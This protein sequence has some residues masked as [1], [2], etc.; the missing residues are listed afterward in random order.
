MVS[1]T[2]GGDRVAPIPVSKPALG[3]EE[4]AQVVEVLRS[5]WVGQGP[6]V[7]EFERQ[8][9]QVLG[10][11]HAVAVSSG[12]A[13]L[14]V[15]LLTLGIGP[16]DAVLVPDF[17]FP[18]SANAVRHCGAEPILLDIDL[19]TLNLSLDGLARFLEQ[20]TKT[21]SG[22]LIDRPSGRIIKAIMAV[23]L[24]GLPLAM[25]L[26]MQLAGRYGLA[27]V[28]DA[29]CALGA[30]DHS[31]LCGTVAE[32]GCFSFHPR[33]LIT[34]GEGGLLVTG[35]SEIAERARSLRNHGMSRTGD[36]VAFAH[37]GFNYRMSDVSAAVGLAQVSKLQAIVGCHDEIAFW[38]DAELE[39]CAAL[40]L[41]K[42][43]EGRI[44]QAYVV[45]VE[46][47]DIRDRVIRRLRDAG[48]ESV[49]GTYAVSAQPAYGN[50]PVCPNALYAQQRGLA[51]PL[52]T[53]L[54][55]RT[56]AR[57][58]AELRHALAV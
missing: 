40:R 46:H 44:Y 58:A 48:I 27:I 12:T 19:D 51:L 4:E 30:R 47:A 14:H 6:K 22:D 45:L 49:P 25:Q 2:A 39:T 9:A 28:E 13:A 35:R 32:V 20:Q 57:I 53:E 36:G 43:V 23:H 16:G 31:G 34:T 10:V 41:P 50:T 7:A 38:Y 54:E 3:P 11:E 17:T 15:A 24:F 18:A 1:T 5:R 26:L 56:V 8:L 52:H 33:K 42:R 29:A 37:A 55:R 21:A